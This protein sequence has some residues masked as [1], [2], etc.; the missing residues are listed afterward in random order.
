MANLGHPVPIC[1]MFHFISDYLER[2]NRKF[3]S[4][5]LIALGRENCYWS[6]KPRGNLFLI[7][8]LLSDY[9]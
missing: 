2:A 7:P 3:I 4:K 5:R 9:L 1:R 6:T 8:I